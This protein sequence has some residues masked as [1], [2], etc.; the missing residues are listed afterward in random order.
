MAEA[1]SARGGRTTGSQELGRRGEDLAA[2]YLHGLG[3]VLLSRNWRCREGELD[4]IVTDGRTL[5]VCEVKTRSGRAFGH[6][7]E[8]VTPEKV[9]RIRRIACRWMSAHHVRWCPVRFDVVAIDW[10]HGGAPSVQHIPGA[11]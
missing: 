8:A 9:A 5:V 6:P 11:F 1:S 3:L 2:E 10:P 4:L 7:A